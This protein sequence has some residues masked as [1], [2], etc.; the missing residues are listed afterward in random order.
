MYIKIQYLGIYSDPGQKPLLKKLKNLDERNWR[1][2]KQME[3]YAQLMDL[4]ILDCENDSTSQRNLE[5]QCHSYQINNGVIWRTRTKNSQMCME[6]QTN[7]IKKHK[8]ESMMLWIS[9]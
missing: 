5:I 6:T 7:L 2:H 9:N 4:N 3:R 8:P 1:Q